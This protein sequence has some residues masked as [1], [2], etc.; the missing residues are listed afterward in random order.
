VTQ[1]TIRR[2]SVEWGFL[3]ECFV[4]NFM[5]APSAVRGAQQHRVFRKQYQFRGLLRHHQRAD[6][7]FNVAM[8]SKAG[9]TSRNPDT[10]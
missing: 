1:M 6:R 8:R 4:A 10:T 7:E 9:A 3:G 2:R 5:R